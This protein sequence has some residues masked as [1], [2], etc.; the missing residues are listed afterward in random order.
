QVYRGTVDL[1]FETHWASAVLQPGLHTITI[2]VTGNGNHWIQVSGREGRKN[3]LAGAFEP[4]PQSKHGSLTLVNVNG[5]YAVR[6]FDAGLIG[7]QF[8]FVVPKIK[9]AERGSVEPDT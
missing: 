7:T 3:I 1:P 2:E 4:E 6:R 8:A 5:T 9:P